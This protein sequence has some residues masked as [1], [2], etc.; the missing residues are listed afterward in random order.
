MAKL[1]LRQILKETRKSAYNGH[2]IK[3]LKQWKADLENLDDREDKKSLKD[4]IMI[5]ELVIELKKS[6]SKNP[7][8]KY[9]Q[10]FLFVVFISLLFVAQASINYNVGGENKFIVAEDISTFFIDVDI[11]NNSLLDISSLDFHEGGQIIEVEAMIFSTGIN[12]T[13]RAIFGADASFPIVTAEQMADAGNSLGLDNRTTAFLGNVINIDDINN[14]SRFKELNLNNGTSALSGFTAENDEG[15][16]VNFGISS[17]NFIFGD[18]SL[19]NAPAIVSFSPEGFT[20]INAFNGSWKWRVQPA[21]SI[22]RLTVAELSDQGNYNISGNFTGNQHYGEMFFLSIENPITTT[23]TE[24]GLEGR[25]NITGF[26]SGKNNG[27]T[28][29][30]NDGLVTNVAGIY[31]IE[32]NLVYKDATNSRHGFAATINNVIQNNTGSG[33]IIGNANDVANVAASGFI[34]LEQGDLIN[35]MVADRFAPVSDIEVLGASVNLIRI[36]H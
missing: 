2:G 6:K 10:I 29:N 36:G 32:Y 1:D 18:E 19:P 22:N 11:R 4:A 16:S 5:L 23:I 21:T 34:R 3:K 28:Y 12:R 25:Q 14:F 7:R 27:F 8:N 13:I 31:N 33:A 20:Y 26:E 15:F 30:G 24:V 17:S 35:V 9:K